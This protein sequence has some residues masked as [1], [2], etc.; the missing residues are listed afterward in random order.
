MVI[1]IVPL[2]PPRFQG[3]ALWADFSGD[4]IHRKK[5]DAQNNSLTPSATQFGCIKLTL[6]TLD[7]F[8]VRNK[9]IDLMIT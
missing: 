1:I 5:D 4:L 8:S 9:Y 6:P 3:K 2:L 7:K